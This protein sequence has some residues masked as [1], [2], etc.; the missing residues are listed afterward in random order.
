[1]KT[2]TNFDW[3][4]GDVLDG[5]KMCVR[6]LREFLYEGI[7]PSYPDSSYDLF[8]T[9]LSPDTMRNIYGALGKIITKVKKDPDELF[10][11]LCGNK[12]VCCSPPAM[13]SRR[14]NELDVSY[15]DPDESDS[16]DGGISFTDGIM[17][18]V[19]LGAAAA[20][21]YGLYKAM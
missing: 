20:L 8:A 7:L 18:G 13:A 10:T 11:Y 19:G 21:G 16:S 15:E 14:S 17:I 3:K 6:R 1:M 2:Q 9:K 12:N 5:L 4:I